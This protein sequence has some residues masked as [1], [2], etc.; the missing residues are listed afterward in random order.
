MKTVQL[1][2]ILFFTTVVSAQS[3][4]SWKSQPKVSL[5]EFIDVFYVYD[6]NQPQGNQRQNFLFNHNRH[7]EFNINLALLKIKVEHKKYRANLGLQLGT[8]PID[9]FA[10]EPSSYKFISE[11]NVGI[12]L[13]KKNTLWLDAGV[14]GSHI[15]FE[16]AI[17][18]VNPTLTRSLLAENSP[19][20]LTGA[21]ITAKPSKHWTFSGLV[22]NGWQR[23]QR[24]DGNSLLSFG[25][26]VNYSKA[27]KFELNW[28]TFVG[29]EDPDSTRRMRYFNNLYA[30]FS[31]SK[32]LKMIVGFDI[33][34]QQ[35]SKHSAEYSHWLTPIMIARWQLSPK[36][37]TA[38][39]LEYYDD[40]DNVMVSTANQQSFQT[41]AAS[42]N[43]DFSPSENI[44]LRLEARL[45]QSPNEIFVKEVNLTNQNLFIGTSIAINLEQV[46][47][48]ESS[49]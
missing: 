23:I 17:S 40:Q 12:S 4:S 8:Y 31:V 44:K 18:S 19:Y 21:K 24:V 43:F 48:K 25:S 38:L 7:N 39:R 41:A 15:G 32:K 22:V 6:F 13:N 46:I 33:G 27:E 42:I 1:S 29:T 49:N 2:I 16:S 10:A 26:Q 37:Q 11:A 14:F 45:L 35:K 28:S 5:K 9:N 47:S 34:V 20:F 36:W 3:D 30:K